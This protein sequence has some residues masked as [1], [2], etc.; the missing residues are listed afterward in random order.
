MKIFYTYT[1]IHRYHTYDIYAH[2]LKLWSDK[3]YIRSQSPLKL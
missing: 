2:T 1:V 3:V